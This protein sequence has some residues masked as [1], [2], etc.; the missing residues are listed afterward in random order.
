M[1]NEWLVAAGF[2]LRKKITHWV[3]MKKAKIIAT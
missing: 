1:T 3:E 2:S